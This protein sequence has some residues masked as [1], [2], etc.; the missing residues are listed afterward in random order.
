MAL[1]II[2]LKDRKV[3]G[4]HYVVEERLY[5]TTDG[6]VVKDGDP[7]A[8]FVFLTPGKHIPRKEAEA[9]GLVTKPEPKQAAKPAANKQASK[10]RDKSR[11]ASASKQG[12]AEKADT[13]V[14]ADD[15]A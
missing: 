4:R 6:R 11:A 12:T 9:L 3:D 8:A 5:K 10:A 14:K 15:D 13:A 1:E 7:D 2:E